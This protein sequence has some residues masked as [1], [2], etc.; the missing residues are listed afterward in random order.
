MRLS[1]YFSKKIILIF[2]IVF[3]IFLF[4]TIIL[5]WID[6]LRFDFSKTIGSKTLAYLA[7]LKTPVTIHPLIPIITLLTSVSFFISISRNSELIIIRSAGRS[8]LRSL[9]YPTATI[10]L[11]GLFVILALNPFNTIMYKLYQS[12][13]K[14][15]QNSLE[16]YSIRD[17]GIWLREGFSTGQRVI[18]AK[19]ASGFK[20]SLDEVTIFE[21]DK[22][23][24]PVNR[25]HAKEAIVTSEGW[26][27]KDGKIWK[28]NRDERPEDRSK[29][30]ETYIVK[31]ELTFDKIKLG[32]GEPFQ[33]SFWDLPT[34][35]KGIQKAG[36]ST[37]KHKLYFN[38]EL[39][40][41]FLMI[42]MFLIG[43][44]L[45]MGHSKLTKTGLMLILTIVLGVGAYLLNN[46][47][48]ILSQ[49]GAIPILLGAWAPPLITIL[50]SLG[51]ILHLEDG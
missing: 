16:S 41:P 39:A 49:N 25:I 32:F 23:R 26:I 45:N 15:I 27:L 13:V 1:F 38:T 17:E 22:N 36:F 44:M 40:L 20:R 5:N 3:F 6:I 9:F 18:N 24:L 43:G 14:L 37:L 48:Q 50:V 19:S 11:I 7:I 33:V 28:V 29:S 21:F 51:L 34:F 4:F 30:F 42:G 31:T 10:F 2:C 46:F 47:T 12:E 35:I 8:I